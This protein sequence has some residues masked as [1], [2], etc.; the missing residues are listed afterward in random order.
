M[1]AR[2]SLTASVQLGLSSEWRP[3]MGRSG[4]K[5]LTLTRQVR[6]LRSPS[7]EYPR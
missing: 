4:R 7:M 5:G 1:R 2:A 3:R 6:P